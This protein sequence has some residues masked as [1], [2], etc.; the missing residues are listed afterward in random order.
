MSQKS[1]PERPGKYVKVPDT[2]KGF[3]AVAEGQYDDVPEQCFYMCGGIEEVEENA[4][5]LGWS[6]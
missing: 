4:K 6:R 3:K 5:K 2:I 1:L